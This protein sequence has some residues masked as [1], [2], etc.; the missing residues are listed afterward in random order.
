MEGLGWRGGT[1]RDQG[2]GGGAVEGWDEIIDCVRN[3]IRGKIEGGPGNR[4]G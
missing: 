2:H 4:E 1:E 3:G